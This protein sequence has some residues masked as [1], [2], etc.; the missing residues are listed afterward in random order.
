[1]IRPPLWL[2]TPRL[3]RLWWLSGAA[4]AFA[5]ASESALGLWLRNFSQSTGG[6]WLAGLGLLLLLR[7][8]LSA[9]RDLASEHL[10][11]GASAQEHA[12]GWRR[13]APLSQEQLGDLEAGTRAALQLRT[14]ALSL[15]LLL[16]TMAFLAPALSLGALGCALLL[17]LVSR[18]RARS[19][20]TLVALDLEARRGFEA[21]ELWAR[22]ALPE[23]RASGLAPHLARLRRSAS[24]DL[25]RRRLHHALRWQ[26]LQSFMELAAHASSLGLCALAFLQWQS[27]ALPLGRF[28]A[29]LALALLAYRPVR[30]AGRALPALARLQDRP[31][32]PPPAPSGS[33]SSLRLEGL[34]FGYREPLFIDFA[35]SLAPGQVA[36][37]HGPN[38]CGKTTLLRLC[39][40]ELSPTGGSIERPR[41]RV[42]WVDQETVLPP[43]SLRRWTGRAA[44]P[45]IP[46]VRD[47]LAGHVIP[48]LPPLDWDA[49]IP[50]GGQNLSRGQRVRLRLAVLACSPGSLW[51]LDE[52]LSALPRPERIPL[53]QAL[54]ACRQHAAVLISDQEL[55]D[56]ET[57]EVASTATG[58]SL[59]LLPR[60]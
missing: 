47:F 24:L 19:L 20:R 29:F 22:R 21:Q 15:L 38:G 57:R 11:L 41:G 14:G 32:P 1:M 54:L 17:G 8:A 42:H 10:A 40:G 26:G 43:F 34:R 12:L 53:L 60:S 46:A 35:A 31:E 4:A 51:L 55:P 37:L 13:H 39:A 44:P 3:R 50:D 25:L 28:L 36:L 58:L 45:D 30:E 5:A 18:R 59:R 33:G 52:P 9:G 56:L 7:L 49:P 2:A 48:F 16:P 27:G 23:V 6:T